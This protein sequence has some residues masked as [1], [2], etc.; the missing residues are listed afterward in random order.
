MNHKKCSRIVPG[1]SDSHAGCKYTG[2][3]PGTFLFLLFV[4]PVSV[5]SIYLSTSEAEDRIATVAIRWRF[6]A[7]GLLTRW[8]GASGGILTRA[9][10]VRKFPHSFSDSNSQLAHSCI[11]IVFLRSRSYHLFLCPFV[12]FPNDL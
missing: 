11:K 6:D 7:C 12:L 9:I 2:P 5:S 4:L 1:Y 3:F 10:R 8:L